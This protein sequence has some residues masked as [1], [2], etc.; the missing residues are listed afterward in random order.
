M[1]IAYWAVRAGSNGE[2]D[3]AFLTRNVVAIGW[4]KMGTVDVKERLP[5]GK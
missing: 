2:M 5:K 1:N 4:P 3:E